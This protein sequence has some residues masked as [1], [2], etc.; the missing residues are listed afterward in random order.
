MNHILRKSLVAVTLLALVGCRHEPPA[1]QF[2]KVRQPA[3]AGIFY[4]DKAAELEREVDRLLAD[5]KAEPIYD[6]QALVCPHA[7]YEFPP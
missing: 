7:G 1:K 2:E 6:L 3:V 5:A 4:P